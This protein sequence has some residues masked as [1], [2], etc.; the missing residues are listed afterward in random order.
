MRLY[1]NILLVFIARTSLFVLSPVLYIASMII[2]ICKWMK[3][4]VAAKWKRVGDDQRPVAKYQLRQAI[5]LDMLSNTRGGPFWN[6]I[7]FNWTARPKVVFGSY[8]DTMSYV[9][10]MNSWI[11]RRPLRI[12]RWT[13]HYRWIRTETLNY[14]G[15][16]WCWFLEIVDPGHLKAATLPT[17]SKYDYL[18]R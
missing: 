1:I 10:G 3:Y 11:E 6:L 7:F 17:V 18:I 5:S 14:H 8:H 16:F 4:K 9:F 15:I 13:I 2:S 12:Y